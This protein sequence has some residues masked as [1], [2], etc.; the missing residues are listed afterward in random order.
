MVSPVTYT[1]VNV[2]SVSTAMPP[3]KREY[4]A[5]V[6]IRTDAMKAELSRLQAFEARMLAALGQVETHD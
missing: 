4:R 1:A 5:E 2:V 3:G 6:K